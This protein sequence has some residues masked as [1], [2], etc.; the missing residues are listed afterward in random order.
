[1]KTT[2][3]KTD[4]IAALKE[5]QKAP[6]QWEIVV[7]STL[8]SVGTDYNI[9]KWGIKTAMGGSIEGFPIR[10]TAIM[11]EH[12]SP[13]YTAQNIVMDLEQRVREAKDE[14]A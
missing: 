13:F 6:E 3:L 9:S 14:E 5:L 1:M 2:N 11:H 4:L 7:R 10:V 12:S 8:L